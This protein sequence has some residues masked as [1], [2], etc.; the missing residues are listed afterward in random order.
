MSIKMCHNSVEITARFW[1]LFK[2]GI[3]EL[4]HKVRGKR[5]E[6]KIMIRQLTMSPCISPCISCIL[7]YRESSI[8]I[9]S[10]E[11]QIS[12]KKYV[13]KSL[14]GMILGASRI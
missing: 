8:S 3:R 11:P 1:S 13:L 14:E 2:I 12:L 4:S 5:W 6:S 9:E 7:C 10:V